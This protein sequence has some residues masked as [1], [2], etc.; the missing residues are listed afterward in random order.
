MRVRC[1]RGARMGCVR[2]VL[3]E[4]DGGSVVSVIL[5]VRGVL[6]CDLEEL[7]LEEWK[8]ITSI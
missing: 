3:V 2:R 1:V 8:V 5:C 6:V 7:G 4:V